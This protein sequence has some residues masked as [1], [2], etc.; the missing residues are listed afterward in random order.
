MKYE[1]YFGGERIKKIPET[2]EQKMGT[3][4]EATEATMTYGELSSSSF[5]QVYFLWELCFKAPP[6]RYRGEFGRFSG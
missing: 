3:L 6:H 2:A 4:N 5:G 1:E